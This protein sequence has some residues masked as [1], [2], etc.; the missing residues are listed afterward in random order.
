M[1]FKV[2]DRIRIRE[3]DDMV[4]EFGTNEYGEIPCHCVFVPE[5][6]PTCGKEATISH[7]SNKE[8]LLTDTEPASGWGYTFSTAMIEHAGVQLQPIPEPEFLE[9][10]K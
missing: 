7:L 5:M 9:L 3:W 8:V 4:A 2:G 1:D 6:R 10:F